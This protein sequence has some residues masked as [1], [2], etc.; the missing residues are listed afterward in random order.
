[1]FAKCSAHCEIVGQPLFLC[2][3]IDRNFP[4]ILFR[5]DLLQDGDLFK[6]VFDL[7]LQRSHNLPVVAVDIFHHGTQPLERIRLC[8]LAHICKRPFRSPGRW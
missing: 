2:F 1:M 6:K 5:C 4:S 3:G 7:I 8:C